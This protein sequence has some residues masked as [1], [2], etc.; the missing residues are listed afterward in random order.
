M[1][2][3]LISPTPSFSEVKR[4]NTC[5]KEWYRPSWAI[6]PRCFGKIKKS[7]WLESN[8]ESL[9]LIKQFLEANPKVK[10][11]DTFSIICPDTY[12]KNYDQ[13]SLMYTDGSHLT[14]HGA[15]KLSDTIENSIETK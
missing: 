10:Y 14:S 4:A 13:I 3:I 8:N 7:E 11:M 5:Q 2:F 15:M 1:E 6:S 12:C 9:E